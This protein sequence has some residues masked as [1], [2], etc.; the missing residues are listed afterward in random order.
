MSDVQYGQGWDRY[1]TVFV[2]MAWIRVRGILPES[3]SVSNLRHR[4]EY[5]SNK[6]LKDTSFYSSTDL[7]PT[8]LLLN[9]KGKTLKPP[10]TLKSGAYSAW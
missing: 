9:S 4:F 8:S 7:N 2:G 1:Y 3:G 10:D 6:E 5:S